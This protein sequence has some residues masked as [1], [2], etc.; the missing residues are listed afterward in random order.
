MNKLLNS[1]LLAIAFASLFSFS[2]IALAAPITGGTTADANIINKE[3]VL[4][5]LIKRGELAANAT[6]VEK[7]LAIEEFTKR[8]NGQKKLPLIQAQQQRKRLD[9]AKKRSKSMS[10]S[11]SQVEGFKSKTV[12]VLTVLIDFPDL[13]HD[14]NGLTSSDTQMFYN[15]YSVE[16]YRSLLFSNSGYQ[17]P[18]GQTLMTGY[19]YYQAESGGSFFFTGDVKGWYRAASN[20]AVYGSNDPDDNDN[21]IA[22]SDLVKEAVSAAVARMSEAELA[23]YDIED[24][25]DSNNNGITNE[26]DGI[27][28][29][30]M[31]F[32]SSIGE[33][34]GGGMLGGDAI[35]SHRSFVDGGSYRLPGTDMKLSGYTIQPIDAALGVCVHEFGHDLGLPD[36]YDTTSLGK[37]SPVGFWSIMAG[38]SWAGELAGSLPTGFS[39]YARSY[40]Q[41]IYG[42]NWVTEQTVPLDSITDSGLDINLVAAV[43]HD[44]VNQI[45]VE[46]PA[47]DIDFKQPYSG[48]F[49]F[50]SDQ[51]DMINHAMSFDIDLP[52]V[53]P[54]T[55]T[56]QAHWSIEEDYDYAQVMVDGVAIA[57]LYTKASNLLNNERNII[58]GKSSDLAAAEGTDAWVNLSYDLSPYAGR[59][60]RLSIRYVTD[61]AVGDYGIVIDDININSNS[62]TVFS[63]D[64]ELDEGI[65]YAGF[66]RLGNMRPG[67]DRRYL[68][69]L[70]SQQG[71]D[72]GLKSESYDPGVVVWFENQDYSDNE[73][74]NHPGYSLISVVDADQNL[75]GSND[76]SVQV[77]DAAFS[78]FNQ[79]SYFNDD[80]LSG[81][82]LFDDTNDYSAPLQPESGVVLPELGLT[83]EVMAQA[84]NSSNATVQ[85][86]YSSQTPPDSKDLSASISYSL[87]GRQA[88]FAANANGGDGSYTYA[89][90][91]GVTDASSTEA[92]PSY[93]Y[94]TDGNYLVSLTV[95]DGN[96]TSFVNYLNIVV[97]S[98]IVVDF[99]HSVSNLQ[100]SFMDQS[101]GGNGELSHQ[102]E[103]G[104]G[105][106]SS[107]VSPI[108]TYGAAG[109]YSVL[110]TVTDNMGQQ[111]QKSVTV[112]ITAAVVESGGESSGGGSLGWLS[113]LLL[114]LLSAHR[115]QH[116]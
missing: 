56:M 54:L 53:S 30:V 35:W 70:R 23:S 109:S 108:Y 47:V 43:N 55:L 97:G 37:G 7:E 14:D 106:T 82:K 16:H 17:G 31:I 38:G 84:S 104:D 58:T 78:L 94:A 5:W 44:K 29:H 24:P 75:I 113:L 28:D 33:E 50:Y 90:D 26:A 114:G 2:P 62:E 40:L 18:Q 102:W 32:H 42:G 6:D 22:A 51:G 63:N 81:S 15:D 85:F 89:W 105:N 13:P 76:S 91:F 116:S 21:D 48:D 27:I 92:S 60:V 112:T 64:A 8:A 98:A 41:N 80:H 72:K 107:A 100:V 49:Q 66:T 3:Q 87:Q 77:R 10:L 83:M 57:G 103:F 86:R 71:I 67:K 99:S 4:Y 68:V 1:K 45:S 73:V 52:A 79:S 95:T 74:N 59:E 39:P 46:V 34:A 69:Q 11:D 20:A 19:Q 61:P 88:S 65:A 93:T 111:A 12:K 101:T 36:E 115:R 96:G 9:Q 110:L 25:F